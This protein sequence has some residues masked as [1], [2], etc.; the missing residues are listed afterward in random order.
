M[1]DS[2][3]Q[4]RYPKTLLAGTAI[5]LLIV[6]VAAILLRDSLIGAIELYNTEGTA[7][8]YYRLKDKIPGAS[9]N[10]TWETSTAPSLGLDESKLDALRDSLIKFDTKA[11]IF[12]RNNRIGYE[13]YAPEQSPNRKHYTSSM[14]KLVAG[15]ML[16]QVALSDEQI[17]MDD[18]L[19][20]YIPAWTEDP[21]R[22]NITA[23]HIITH[24]SGIENVDFKVK[25]TDWKQGYFDNPGERFQ[26]AMTIA[27]IRFAPGSQ[28]EYSGVGFY[29]L[30]Y[31]LG[32][33]MRDSEVRDFKLILRDRI[34]RPLGI[35]DHDWSVSYEESY[36]IDDMPLIAIGSG[37]AYTPR[38]VARI[39]QLLL[40]GGNW[41]GQQLIDKRW[42]DAMLRY[43]ESPKN[44]LEES[45]SPPTGIAVWLNCNGFWSS[46]PRDAVIA[47]GGGHQLL[48]IIPSYD[49]VV[50][51]MGNALSDGMWNDIETAFFAP[52]MAALS[53][54]AYPSGV[55]S[56]AR[57]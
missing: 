33:A 18:P 8:I 51:R 23:R 30:A 5:V 47:H 22:Q 37:G 50:V 7:G 9:P 19:H 52:L 40:N 55:Q 3:W 20:R 2:N 26:G 46:L 25:H 43:G 14:T 21:V 57:Q 53:E 38:A 12:V 49:L 17:G 56:C 54:P 39:G 44:W 24:S 45:L 6:A 28:Y 1:S 15:A 11:L 34:M 42:A 27:P 31:A 32:V 10:V 35:P 13:Y 36:E 16:L 41:D 29:A 48:L 4:Q